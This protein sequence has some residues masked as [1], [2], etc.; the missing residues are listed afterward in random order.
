MNNTQAIGY[1]IT[2]FESLD[3][4]NDYISELLKKNNIQ[5]GFIVSTLLQTKGKGQK[6]N[7]WESENAKNLLMSV[8]LAPDFINASSQFYLNKII[9][10][11]VAEFIMEFTTDVFIKWPNDIYVNS[12]KIAGILI[13]NKI[14]GDAIKNSI[15][16]I[17]ININQEVFLSDAHNPISL[18]NITKVEYNINECL[19]KLCTYLNK[20]YDALRNDNYDLIDNTYMKMLMNYNVF[21]KYHYN[22]KDIIA[23]ITALSEYGMLIL[24][25]EDGSSITCD[26]KEIVFLFD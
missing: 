11:S 26:M 14:M 25:L 23:K 5:E 20:W 6:G 17:G 19:D 2:Q 22:G 7:S 18:K 21:S 4:T 3:S 10:L 24:L 1:Y 8:L 13:E 12:K 9:S 15:I 16:G